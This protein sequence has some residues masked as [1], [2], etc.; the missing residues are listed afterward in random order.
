MEKKNVLLYGDSIRV[1]YD[2]SVKYAMKDVAN[3]YFPSENSRFA[4]YLFRFMHDWPG[5]CGINPADVDCVHWN[6]GLWDTLILDEEGPCTSLDEYKKVIGRICKKMKKVFPKATF[7]FATS[8]PMKSDT[9]VFRKN[10]DIEIYNKAAVE[11]AKANGFFIDDL[12]PM[13]KDAPKD[14]YSDETHLYT[15][16]GALALTKQVTS[17]ICTTLGINVPSVSDEEIV[18][19]LPKQIVVYGK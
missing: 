19:N 13:V 12:Y 16:A 1:G 4:N 5:Q 15:E 2:V 8:T 10:S 6:A 18:A 14:W 11:I 17:S 3:V 7:I 9:C